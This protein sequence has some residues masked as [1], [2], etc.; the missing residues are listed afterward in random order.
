[1]YYTENINMRKVIIFI[2]FNDTLDTFFLQTLYQK[3]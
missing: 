3:T 2:F 1:M